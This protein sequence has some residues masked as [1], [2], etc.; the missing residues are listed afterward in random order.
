[1]RNLRNDE[2]HG[3]D[4]MRFM[5]GMCVFGAPGALVAGVTAKYIFDA[6]RESWSHDTAPTAVAG[7]T[8]FV[9]FAVITVGCM[10]AGGQT[11]KRLGVRG[12]F[13]SRLF[14]C[15]NRA[16]EASAAPHVEYDAGL[17]RAAVPV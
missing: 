6:V 12:A 11:L 9:G 5:L 3:I 4:E 14:C 2:P 8:A 13:D 10:V 15:C 16:S 17:T 7:I 1:M